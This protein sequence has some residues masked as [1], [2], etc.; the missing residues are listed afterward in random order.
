MIRFLIFTLLVS[1]LISCGE[2]VPEETDE[3]MGPGKAIVGIRDLK[4]EEI[5]IAT[6]IC[7]SLK[8]K[9]ILFEAYG[10]SGLTTFFN[11]KD[12]SCTGLV[13]VK[14]NVEATLRYPLSGGPMS[15]EAHNGGK[16]HTQI[17]TDL[18]GEL[19]PYCN[20]IFSKSKTPLSNRKNGTDFNRQYRFLK[21]KGVNS[22]E[23]G[24]FFSEQ[25]GGQLVRLQ[26]FLVHNNGRVLEVRDGNFTCS[27]GGA[28]VFIQ[29][30]AQ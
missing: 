19:Q 2:P 13:T 15:F 20:Q 29:Q 12:T 8:E 22:F 9:R 18:H 25:R 14:M 21:V 3:R 30:L 6:N 17:E 4:S 11:T 27:N 7:N 23:V 28:R 16:L 26:T 10:D 24:Q 5:T 1:T